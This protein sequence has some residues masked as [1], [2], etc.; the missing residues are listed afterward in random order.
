MEP[1][2]S[3]SIDVAEM[4]KAS[5]FY[6]EALSCKKIRDGDDITVVLAEN[7][8][9]YLLKK[10]PGSNP[11][12]VGDASRNYGRHWT[13][14]HIDFVVSNIDETL[15]LVLKYGGSHE[16]GESGEWGSIAYCA[17]PF[18]N[19]FCLVVTQE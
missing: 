19:G 1:K 15:S 11:L 6:C 12:L 3:I 13:P 16:G 14:V 2:I 9:I 17:D 7:A 4:E 5:S 10:D 8:T 18:G